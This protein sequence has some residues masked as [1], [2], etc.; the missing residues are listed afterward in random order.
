MLSQ[1]VPERRWWLVAGPGSANVLRSVPE[2]L[3][4]CLWARADHSAEVFS[5]V[6]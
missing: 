6:S 3:T 5:E 4:I 2:S 1:T